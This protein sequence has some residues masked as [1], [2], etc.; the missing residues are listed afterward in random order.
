MAE[1][2]VRDKGIAA[3]LDL[4]R[5]YQR[6]LETEMAAQVQK[7]AASILAGCIQVAQMMKALTIVDD[8]GAI[9]P[10]ERAD[11]FRVAI[12]VLNWAVADAVSAAAAG[13]RAD[14]PEAVPP[15]DDPAPSA[16]RK[17]KVGLGSALKVVPGGR[18]GVLH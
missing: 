3:S 2:E 10:E 16:P 14:P 8:A 7:R 1:D 18:P 9:T 4:L 5:T 12:I 6:S 15:P 13:E 11:F 17:E